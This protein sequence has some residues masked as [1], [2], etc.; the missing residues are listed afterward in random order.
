MQQTEA[1]SGPILPSWFLKVSSLNL[2]VF[3]LGNTSTYQSRVSDWNDD[4]QA[5]EYAEGVLN[6]VLSHIVRRHF[7]L[8]EGQDG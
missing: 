6:E 4:W 5:R 2:Y 1:K 3:I 7:V 8:R